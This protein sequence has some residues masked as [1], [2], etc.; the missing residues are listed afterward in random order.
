MPRLF[1]DNLTVIDFS[2]ACPKRGIVGASW[3]VDIILEGELNEQGMVFDFGHVKKSIKH[4]IDDRYDHKLWLSSALPQYKL[5]QDGQRVDV[6]WHD[7]LERAYS[8]SSPESAV[9]LVSESLIDCKTFET[10]IANDIQQMLPANVC[11]VEITLR[12]EVIEGANYCY[13]HGLQAH[14]GNC[15]RI[16]HGHRSRINI[17]RNDER[18]HQLEQ[19]WAAQWEDIYL[20][21][22]SHIAQQTNDTTTVKYAAEQG[23]FELTMPSAKVYQTDIVSTVENIAS[24]LA[25]ACKKQYPNDSITV[26]AFEGVAKGAIACA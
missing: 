2:F 25:T 14:D 8:H 5:A 6:Q 20:A 22:I 15:Q 18:D 10:I 19:Q 3:I 24:Y 16:A 11:G 17:W 21:T 23:E 26:H 9:Y 1:V 4:F 12:E 13:T 7:D